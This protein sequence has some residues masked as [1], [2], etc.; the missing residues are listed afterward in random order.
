MRNVWLLTLAQA[1]AACGTIMLVTFG[2]IVGT[3]LAPSAVLATLPVS[4]SIFGVASTS[5]PAALLMQRIGRANHRLDEPSRA[6]IAPANRFEVLESL[7]ALEASSR[8]AAQLSSH[9]AGVWSEAFSSPRGLRSTP[10]ATRRSAA[11]G[12]S[13]R[14]SMRRPRSR[15]Q[16]PA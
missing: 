6:M 7:A 5:L 3:E 9:Q 15:C 11:W 13:S 2:G 8:D 1:F 14:W 10:A 12:E 4:I 16:A